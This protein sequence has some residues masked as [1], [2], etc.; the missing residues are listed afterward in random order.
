[1]SWTTNEEIIG[2]DIAIDEIFF[3]YSLYPG[4]LSRQI[5]AILVNV[6][7]SP[8]STANS[9]Y[10]LFCDHGNGLVAELSATYIKQIFQTWPKHANYENIIQSLLAEIISGRK[11]GYFKS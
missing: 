11:S 9:P 7:A 2:F 6:T 8:S 3:M 5:T 10:H 4:Y 1:M